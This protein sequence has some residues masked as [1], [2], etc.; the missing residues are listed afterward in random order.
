MDYYF[1]VI[2]PENRYLQLPWEKEP[3]KW[4]KKSDSEFI[5][6]KV[7]CSI[8]TLDQKI[9]FFKIKNCITTEIKIILRNNIM[10]F[11]NN[12]NVP[13]YYGV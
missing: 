9:N 12:R 8:E 5:T 2:D 13:Y 7:L 3:T 1:D 4:I 10:N 11:I 6:L